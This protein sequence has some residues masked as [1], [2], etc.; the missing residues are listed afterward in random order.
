MWSIL[1]SSY[2]SIGQCVENSSFNACAKLRYEYLK[3]GKTEKNT[4]VYDNPL[5]SILFQYMPFLSQP[6]QLNTANF[7]VSM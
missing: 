5:K 6:K 2:I 3:E 4:V 7:Y 1:E